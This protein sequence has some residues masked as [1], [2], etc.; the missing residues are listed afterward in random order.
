MPS[1]ISGAHGARVGAR[2]IDAIADRGRVLDIED[3]ELDG[4]VLIGLPLLVALME[5]IRR[6]GRLERTLPFAARPTIGARQG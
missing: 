4:A 1:H 2:K 6:A 5:M 3:E